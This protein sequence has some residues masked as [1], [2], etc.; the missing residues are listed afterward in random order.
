[1]QVDNLKKYG[2]EFQIKCIAALLSDKSFLE[3]IYEI[4]EPS[5]FETDAN[6]WIVKE[7]KNYFI[8]YKDLPTP[9]V[10]KYKVD[11]LT[12]HIGDPKQVEL[13]KSGI[14]PQ[15]RNVY[16]KTT[17]SDI[18]FIKDEFLTFCINQSMKNAVLESADL[19]KAGEYTKI[20]TVIESA[21]KAG[22]E[23]DLGHD[24]VSDVEQRL[25]ETARS[26]IPTNIP[27][28]DELL[29]GGLGKGELGFI[30]G[31]AGSGKSWILSRFGA[32]ALRQG[33]NVVHFTM[34]LN[35]SYTG[36]RYD[37]CFTGIEFQEIRKHAD[38]IREH[39]KDIKSNLNIKYFPMYSIS[40]G[41]L[42][43][44]I[45]RYQML[46]N[47]KVDLIIVD[48]ADLLR[49]ET[50]E[51]NSNSYHDGGSIYGELRGVA[52]ELQIPIWTASQANRGGYDQDIVEAQHVADSFKKIMIG[53][54]IMSIARKREDKVHS[55]ARFHIAKNRFGPDGLTFPAEFNTDCGRLVLFDPGSREGM[56]IQNKMGDAENSV[57]SLIKNRW[58]RNKTSSEE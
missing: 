1:M 35:Q 45:D 47:K 48:Y 34:E 11:A 27:A 24:Y 58:N 43:L 20:R 12:K 33:K 36:L 28:I 52:G 49:P 57:K 26:C 42:K 13:L 56:E 10:F 54:F 51:K 40:P 8:E 21:L 41:S 15:L 29:D 53:D 31:P 14:I 55:I 25:S 2:A 30:I 39:V 17:E 6:Q 46:T 19:V 7:T 18:K 3:R 44:H 23:K 37:S 38:R 4:L 5:M 22:M 32:E 9:T 16:Q 50:R